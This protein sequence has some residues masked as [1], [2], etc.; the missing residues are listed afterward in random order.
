MSQEKL[1]GHQQLYEKKKSDWQ[2][3]V[4]VNLKMY[5]KKFNDLADKW[6]V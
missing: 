2:K 4:G 3:S 6:N 5:M 1:T